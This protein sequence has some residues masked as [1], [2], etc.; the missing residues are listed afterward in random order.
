LIQAEKGRKNMEHMAEIVPDTD[1]QSLQHFISESDWDE[2]EVLN[3][4]AK[5]RSIGWKRG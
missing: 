4:V 1:S 2:R 5:R 3:Q